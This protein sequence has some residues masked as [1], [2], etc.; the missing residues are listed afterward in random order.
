MHNPT[1]PSNHSA[2]KFHSNP[3]GLGLAGRP[4]I[5]CQV[6]TNCLLLPI[7]RLT[8]TTSLSQSDCNH[9]ASTRCLYPH[10]IVHAQL[11]EGHQRHRKLSHSPLQCH[12]RK[13]LSCHPALHV[14]LHPLQRH[15]LQGAQTAALRLTHTSQ[16]GSYSRCECGQPHHAGEH[17][18]QFDVEQS[19]S[20][21]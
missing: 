7:V 4:S 17:S 19:D 14:I 13:P 2:I 10:Y 1:T 15:T 9:S 6:F 20:S 8:D 16:A 3:P 11:F 21:E 12:I 18:H 5:Q